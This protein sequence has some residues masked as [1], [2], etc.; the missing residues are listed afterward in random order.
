MYSIT[1]YQY[2]YFVRGQVVV[3]KPK[4]AILPR[5]SNGLETSLGFVFGYI[6]VNQSLTPDLTFYA[7]PTSLSYLPFGVKVCV[8][9]Y[10]SRQ[11]FVGATADFALLGEAQTYLNAGARYLFQYPGHKRNV[12]FYLPVEVQYGL[13]SSAMTYQTTDTSYTQ[14]GYHWPTDVSYQTS[15]HSLG[16]HVGQGL[17]FIL[18]QKRSVKLELMFV[19]GFVLSANY[20]DLTGASPNTTFGMGGLRL[21]V[22]YSL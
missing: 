18:P 17:A 20:K 11:H 1:R 21:A 2:D 10:L 16:L 5:K 13:L 7:A 15:L 4:K 12:A 19:K 3:L 6:Q 9:K 14:G 22:L 8:G